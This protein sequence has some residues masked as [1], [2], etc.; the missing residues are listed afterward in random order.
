M[1]ALLVHGR[2]LRNGVRFSV[3]RRSE[4]RMFSL[5]WW[6]CDRLV[7]G[8]EEGRRDRRRPEGGKVMDGYVVCFQDACFRD[9]IDEQKR[10]PSE[11]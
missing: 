9:D 6:V 5:S 8:M 2:S 10:P 11:F 4:G 3:Q 7:D 1:P